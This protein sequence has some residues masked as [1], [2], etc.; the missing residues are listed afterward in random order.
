MAL[1]VAGLYVFIG[2]NWIFWQNACFHG[3]CLLTWNWVL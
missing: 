3:N 2:S 1:F